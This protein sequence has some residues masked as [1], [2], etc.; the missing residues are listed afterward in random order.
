MGL[1][2]PEMSVI[3][4]FRAGDDDWFPYDNYKTSKVY[5]TGGKWVGAANQKAFALYKAI[6]D[7]NPEIVPKK[8]SRTANRS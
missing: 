5:G 7:S 6:V 8:T 2:T 4:T 1:E 3:E